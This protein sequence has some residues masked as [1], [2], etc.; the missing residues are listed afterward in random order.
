MIDLE[1][2]WDSQASYP[3]EEIA[4]CYSQVISREAVIGRIRNIAR[5]IAEKLRN[6]EPVE[7]ALTNHN[8]VTLDPLIGARVIYDDAPRKKLSLTRDPKELA[9]FLKVASITLRT[10]ENGEIISKR[11]IFYQDTRLFGHQRKVDQAVENI[12][13]MIEV[14]RASLGIIACQKGYIA[15]PITWT[16]ESGMTT[17]CSQRIQSIPHN[18]DSIRVNRSDAIAVL[19]IEK[20]AVFMRL[21]QSTIVN[22]CV[23]ITGRGVPDYATR[24][25]VKMIQ[26]IYS[27][28]LLGLFD[29]DPFGFSIF[30]TYKFGSRKAAYDG[31]NMAATNI[32][33]LG[34]RP[35]DMPTIDPK[36]L[37][38]L[39]DNDRIV[40]KRLIDEPDLP[41]IYREELLIM[42]Q[43]NKKAEIE[44]LM[45]ESMPLT[46]IFLPDKFAR[47]DWI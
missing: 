14:P 29:M 21:V 15:G 6:S 24:L 38:E 7:I 25:F 5:D 23:L 32:Q 26:D 45:T 46:D 9:I 39:T 19:V 42:Q 11:A 28:P 47:S 3:R 17:D 31:M 33:W 13:C 34:V 36:N 1:D 8:D 18:I 44:A 4:L 22:E 10:L 30:M 16:D 27:K 12:A 20:E 43:S 37:L 41:D 40:L 35:S 2:I